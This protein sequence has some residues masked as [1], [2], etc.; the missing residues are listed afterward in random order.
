MDSENNY[1][2]VPVN[3]L[4]D[5]VIHHNVTV[6]SPGSD[7]SYSNQNVTN[8]SNQYDVSLPGKE[9]EYKYK[10]VIGKYNSELDKI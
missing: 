7:T 9:I 6:S 1:D 8:V 4:C 2:I 3:N 5:N 10:N